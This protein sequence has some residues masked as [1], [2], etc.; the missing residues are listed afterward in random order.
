MTI[1]GFVVVCVGGDAVTINQT[2][3]CTGNKKKTF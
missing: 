2:R 3:G 1:V